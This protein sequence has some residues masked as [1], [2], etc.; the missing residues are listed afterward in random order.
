MLRHALKRL[1]FEGADGRLAFGPPDH[2]KEIDCR[3]HAA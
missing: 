1:V 3:T 2:P